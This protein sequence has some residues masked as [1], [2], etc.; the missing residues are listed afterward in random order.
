MIQ[1]LVLTKRVRDPGFMS[2]T[3][4]WRWNIEVDGL[5]SF[6]ST[7]QPKCSY[8]LTIDNTSCVRECI[9]SQWNFAEERLWTHSLWSSGVAKW[10]KIDIVDKTEIHIVRVRLQEATL[11]LFSY[12]LTGWLSIRIS[13]PSTVAF[14]LTKYREKQTRRL[15]KCAISIIRE[16]THTCSM[17]QVHSAYITLQG[18][19][20][21]TGGDEGR[22]HH[23]G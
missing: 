21:I 22:R 20:E 23:A 5:R 4:P 13:R 1:S 3:N 2:L 17:L 16:F 19:A 6:N 10:C 14:R 12:L 9:Q 8:Q 18:Q 11:L 7:I 15:D